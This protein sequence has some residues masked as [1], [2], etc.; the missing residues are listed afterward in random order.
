MSIGLQY[1]YSLFSPLHKD[2]TPTIDFNAAFIQAELSE[3]LYMELPPGYGIPG[4]RQGLQ[5]Y[6][7]SLVRRCL[8]CKALVQASQLSS[9]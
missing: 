4:K 1:S 7:V 8:R 3:P 2:N 5:G 6:Q 9:R